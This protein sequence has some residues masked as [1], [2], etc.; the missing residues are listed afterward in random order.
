MPSHFCLMRSSN[1]HA[2]VALSDLQVLVLRPQQILHSSSLCSVYVQELCIPGSLPCPAFLSHARQSKHDIRRACNRTKC[3]FLHIHPK[4]AVPESFSYR[5][6]CRCARLCAHS[7][8]LQPG[9]FP[10]LYA[11]SSITKNVHINYNKH[12]SGQVSAQTVCK[13]VSIHKPVRSFASG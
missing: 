6:G 2:N 10:I 8:Y 12:H 1:K 4:E 5:S 13:I 3:L 7:E 9:K 11:K